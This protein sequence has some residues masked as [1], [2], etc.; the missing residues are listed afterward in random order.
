LLRLIRTASTILFILA[1][2]LTPL[3][4]AEA[5]RLNTSVK[6]CLETPDS[7]DEG[8]AGKKVNQSKNT[9]T[10]VGVTFLD[11]F[12]M[13]FA[14]AFVAG[15][16]YF[17]LRFINKKSMTYKRSQLVENLGGT[18]LGAN[19]SIQVVKAGN[20][21]LIVGVGE[22]IQLLKEID[23]PEE[24][25]QVIQEYNSNMEQL[26]QPSD[27]VTKF[28]KRKNNDSGNEGPAFSAILK[29]QL[30]EMAS[31]RKKV[32]EEMQ[33]KGSDNNE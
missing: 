15:L 23:D 27:F 11:F 7:C 6:D 33:K 21:L 16:L 24:Y 13:I 9:E 2:L 32:L 26:V 20:R 12:R 18:S 1:A 25:R 30:N 10:K 3:G 5:E 22:N 28:L 19:R 8:Q 17:L 31:G 14:T 4:I 29:K